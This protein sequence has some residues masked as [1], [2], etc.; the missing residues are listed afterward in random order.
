M[1]D[2]SADLWLRLEGESPDGAV[3]VAL[4]G[5]DV[6]GRATL[7][8]LYGA[9]AELVLDSP[10]GDGV[11]ERLLEALEGAAGEHNLRRLEL[12][13]GT[14]PPDFVAAVRRTRLTR[15]EHRGEQVRLTWP[16]TTTRKTP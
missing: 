6:V 3:A 9:R 14:A 16:T 7:T 12:D 4:A 5:D 1:R 11:N 13:V 2:A 10:G 15:E 8:R